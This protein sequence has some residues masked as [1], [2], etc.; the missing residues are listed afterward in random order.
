MGTKSRTTV[1]FRTSNEFGYGCHCLVRQIMTFERCER[2]PGFTPFT[3]VT[4]P[5]WAR[6]DAGTW[7]LVPRY[8]N[9]VHGQGNIMVFRYNTFY[10]I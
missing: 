5:P 3:A 2:V 6:P 7:V 10:N 1:A 4:R 8:Y 9:L